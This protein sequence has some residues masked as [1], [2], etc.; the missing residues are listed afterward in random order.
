MRRGGIGGRTCRLGG[1][2]GARFACRRGLGLVLRREHGRQ[3]AGAEIREQIDQ[4]VEDAEQHQADARPEEARDQPLVTP[5]RNTLAHVVQ[6]DSQVGI[7]V[8]RD[9]VGQGGSSDFKRNVC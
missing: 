1:S 4:R 7:G 9:G 3:P 8:K 5:R 2:R 6:D